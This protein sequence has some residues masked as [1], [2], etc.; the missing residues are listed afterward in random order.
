MNIYLN[1]EKKHYHKE[2]QDQSLYRWKTL[3]RLKTLKMRLQTLL[4]TVSNLVSKLAWI[5]LIV[6]FS[7]YTGQFITVTG[8]PSSGKI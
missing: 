8:I 5:T 6:F 3:L 7:T 1:M 4:E 2:Y